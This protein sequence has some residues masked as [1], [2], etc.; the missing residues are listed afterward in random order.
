[1]SSVTRIYAVVLAAVCLVSFRAQAQVS[2]DRLLNATQTAYGLAREP[3]L[4]K[5]VELAENWRPYR[6]W[7]AVCL[8]RTLSGGA[9][10][11]HS[12]AAGL[13]RGR[14]QRFGRAELLVTHHQQMRGA[15]R[16][17]RRIV[18]A[19]RLHRVPSEA[20]ARPEL[21]LLTPEACLEKS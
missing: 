4:A 16:H 2:S 14:R 7:V 20:V 11:M 10:M 3:D 21:A 6:M 9:G 15:G 5:L 17:H 19:A 12:R 1:M 8:R 13:L 18:H